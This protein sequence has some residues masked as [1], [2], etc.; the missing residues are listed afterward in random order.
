VKLDIRGHITKAEKDVAHVTI[1]VGPFEKTFDWPV[2][3]A[4]SEDYY[5]AETFAVPG[6]RLPQPF[7]VSAKATATSAEGGSALVTVD[8]LDWSVAP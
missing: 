2:G 6:G 7:P 5:L 3:K 8:S 1:K 4:E